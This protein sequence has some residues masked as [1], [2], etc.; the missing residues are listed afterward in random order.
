M[1]QWVGR[2]QKTRPGGGASPGIGFDSQWIVHGNPEL[3]LASETPLGRFDGDMSEQE[4]DRVQFATH[5]VAKTGTGASQV[6]RRQLV[7]TRASRRGI[8]DIPQHF[9]WH[10]VSPHLAGFMDRSADAAAGDVRRLRPCV[11]GAFHPCWNRHG[12][13]MAGFADEIANDPMLLALLDRVEPQGQV[14]R[15]ASLNASY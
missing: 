2:I 8:N 15:T 3:L 12:A 14:S 4:L 13:D 11:D 6:V 9:G 7:D 5:Q 10:A 1:S